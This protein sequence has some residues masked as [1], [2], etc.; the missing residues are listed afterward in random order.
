MDVSE[1]SFRFANETLSILHDTV[2]ASLFDTLGS[3]QRFHLIIFPLSWLC[4]YIVGKLYFENGLG[5]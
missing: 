4:F 3:V 2:S 5:M 1:Y